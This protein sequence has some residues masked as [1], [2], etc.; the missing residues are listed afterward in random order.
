VG[1]GQRQV[2]I[3][4]QKLTANRGFGEGRKPVTNPGEGNG[5]PPLK[6]AKKMTPRLLDE[7]VDVTR[8]SLQHLK[9]AARDRNGW[10]ELIPVVTKGRDRPDGRRF[11]YFIYLKIHCQ[12]GL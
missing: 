2:E 9:E 10:R 11:I 4:D 5:K 12:V 1:D 3:Y 6:S 8:R 7:V